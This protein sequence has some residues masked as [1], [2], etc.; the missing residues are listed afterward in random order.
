MKKNQREKTQGQLDKQL[1]LL[2]AQQKISVT[3]SKKMVQGEVIQDVFQANV[4]ISVPS[5][6][7]QR[8]LKKGY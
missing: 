7:S 1:Y 6:Y 5:I 4:K 3:H 2:L 8:W